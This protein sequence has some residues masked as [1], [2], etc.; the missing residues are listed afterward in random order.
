M[1]P[2][3]REKVNHPL[4]A[5]RAATSRGFT[6]IESILVIVIVGVGVLAIVAAQQAYHQQNAY[7]QRVGAALL[8]ANEIRE[9]SMNL[10]QHDPITGTATWGPEGNE[11]TVEQYDDLDDFDGPGGTGLTISPPVDALRQPM[12]DMPGWSQV[13][14]VENLLP[15]MLNG[16]AAP[17]NSTDVVRITAQVLYQGPGDD[18]AAEVTR[19]TWVRAGGL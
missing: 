1:T 5:R 14:T 7:A 11:P 12:A 3:Q 15:N 19:L 18:E 6:L 10:P 4:G 17:D 9:L 13:I 2:V 16:P 8:L